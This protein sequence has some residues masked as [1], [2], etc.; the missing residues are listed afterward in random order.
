MNAGGRPASEVVH[1]ARLTHRGGWFPTSQEAGFE[2]WPGWLVEEEALAQEQITRELFESK[3]GREQLVVEAYR[4]VLR[5]WAGNLVTAFTP[6]YS[7]FRDFYEVATG[8][9]LATKRP[10]TFEERK[11]T[12]VLAMFPF[13]SGAQVRR[14][15]EAL[16]EFREFRRAGVHDVAQATDSYYAGVQLGRAHAETKMGLKDTGWVNPFGAHPTAPGFDDVMEDAAG[17][18]WIV[19]YKGGPHSHLAEGQMEPRWVTENIEKL[20]K[21]DPSWRDK[22]D[23]ARREGRLHG[24]ALKSTEGPFGTTIELQRWNY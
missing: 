1:E 12:A 14:G 18:L 23:K 15:E 16:E 6:I 13:F 8:K 20:R 17:D 19:E 10:L 24:V 11:G 22:L 3:A 7:D 4:K 5:E 21:R 9:D 2:A